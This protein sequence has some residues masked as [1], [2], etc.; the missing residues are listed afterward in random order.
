MND[1]NGGLVHVQAER[2]TGKK[3]LSNTTCFHLWGMSA[4]RKR[5]AEC[6]CSVMS[7]VDQNIQQILVTILKC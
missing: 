2:L 7:A 6:C 5:L 3:L 1:G 4:I